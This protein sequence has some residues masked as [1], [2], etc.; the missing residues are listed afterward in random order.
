M[1][2]Q[3]IIYGVDEGTARI[4]LNRPDV[5]N[6]LSQTSLD[7]IRAALKAAE[8]D[9]GIHVIILAGAGRSFSA[10]RDFNS[11]GEDEKRNI[12]VGK[13]MREVTDAIQNCSKP[14]IAMVH[15]HCLTGAFEIVLACDM[16]IAAE[17]AKFGDLHT[18]FGMRVAAGLSQRLPQLV[19]LMKARELCYTARMVSGLEAERIGLVNR[20][21]PQDKLEETVKQL[22]QEIMANS[23]EAI[24]VYKY[25]FNNGANLMMQKGLDLEIHGTY[26]IHDTEE[27]LKKALKKG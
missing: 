12:N 18:K 14:V 23:A 26:V 5:L 9:I 20:A 19:G 10:G 17:D 3:T 8:S 7:E 24:S 4:T 21:V 27:R 25:L 6:A 13:T 16:I 15:G 2:Y 1:E 22:A 11:L